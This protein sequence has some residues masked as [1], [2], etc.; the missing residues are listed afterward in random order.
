MSRAAAKSVR[1]PRQGGCASTCGGG[2]CGTTLWSNGLDGTSSLSSSW[3]IL[4]GRA[5][6]ISSSCHPG[7]SFSPP[8]L[9]FRRTTGASGHPRNGAGMLHSWLYFS[10]GAAVRR[11][12]VPGTHQPGRR[13]AVAGGLD[14]GYTTR[15]MGP[16][17]VHTAGDRHGY[18][19][20]ASGMMMVSCTDA[21]EHRCPRVAGPLSTPLFRV[22]CDACLGCCRPFTQ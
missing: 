16:S 14:T 1:P 7:G 22:R 21:A 2:H 11:V 17:S 4:V 9:R 20:C 8:G 18:R 6:A 10:M 3:P 5:R 19:A 12:A 15:E 13:E